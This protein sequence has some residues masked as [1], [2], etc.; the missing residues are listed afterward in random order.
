MGFLSGLDYT[1]KEQGIFESHVFYGPVSPLL[2]IEAVDAKPRGSGHSPDRLQRISPLH[3]EWKEE[4][5]RKE[6]D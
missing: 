2:L 1:D 4:G 5:K 6:Q 3:G